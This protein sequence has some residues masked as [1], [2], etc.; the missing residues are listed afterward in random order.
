MNPAAALRPVAVTVG[1]GDWDYE[2]PELPAADWLEALLRGWTGVVPGMLPPEDRVSIL[3]DQLAGA[4]TQED[5]TAAA[6]AAAEVA[7]G[8][9]WW[10]VERLWSTASS[11]EFWEVVSAQLLARVDPARVS[12]GGALNTIY[13]I[14][15]EHMKDDKRHAFDAMLKAPPAE[16]IAQ[17]WDDREAED[18]FMAALS[19]QS[20][21]HGGG[22]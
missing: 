19:Q 14:M 20:K 4:I 5:V 17:E 9:R 22:G 3:R 16:V 7:A 13:V 18:G 21:L 1:L 8:R 11:S 12:L 10:E 15:V 6:R 2:I